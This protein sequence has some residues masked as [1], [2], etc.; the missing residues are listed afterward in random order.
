MSKVDCRDLEAVKVQSLE[1]L[2][3]AIEKVTKGELTEVLVL[4]ISKDNDRESGKTRYAMMN[5]M[6]MQNSLNVLDRAKAFLR[7]S[8]M[9]DMLRDMIDDGHPDVTG[10]DEETNGQGFLAFLA[11]MNGGTKH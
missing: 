8:V 7:K 4:G 1:I 9:V 10:P 6:T 3:T 5:A 11:N 2:N